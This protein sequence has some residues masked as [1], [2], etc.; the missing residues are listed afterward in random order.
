[1]YAARNICI[2][3]VNWLANAPEQILFQH[4]FVQQ[5][6]A[7]VLIAILRT[8]R[9]QS[10]CHKG[11]SYLPP[12][13]STLEHVRISGRTQVAQMLPILQWY[14]LEKASS[15]KSCRIGVAVT[16]KEL[17]E[18]ELA[19]GFLVSRSHRGCTYVADRQCRVTTEVLLPIA[20]SVRTSDEQHACCRFANIDRISG[21]THMEVAKLCGPHC[22]VR[23]LRLWRRGGRAIDILI[24]FKVRRPRNWIV[25]NTVGVDCRHTDDNSGSI[26]TLMGLCWQ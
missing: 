21:Y 22:G 23:R 1:M 2:S 6:L 11:E 19:N 3:L 16:R 25:A 12:V 26:T 24:S 7:S 18:V 9:P 8:Q 4:T 20:V 10:L 17:Y 5:L 13:S 15:L 14:A